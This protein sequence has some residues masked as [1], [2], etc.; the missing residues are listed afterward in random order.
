MDRIM[1]ALGTEIRRS[2]HGFCGLSHAQAFPRC[3]VGHSMCQMHVCQFMILCA[4]CMIL[5]S[6]LN[7]THVKAYSTH[8]EHC[9]YVYILA[10]PFQLVYDI[11]WYTI[12]TLAV[13][14]FA[15][16]GI[17]GI[18]AEIENPF[19]YDDNDLVNVSF[20][21]RRVGTY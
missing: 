6:P 19:G 13:A 16:L 15:I 21:Y 17:L 10:L 12:P 11:G 4:K 5:G 7:I 3:F 18:G 20:K 8:L 9:L 14:A 2:A 1:S